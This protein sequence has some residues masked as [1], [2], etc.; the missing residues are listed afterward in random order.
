MMTKRTGA[1]VALALI[2]MM[3]PAI[4]QVGVSA[5]VT[6]YTQRESMQC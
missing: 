5:K 3:S 6:A 1:I 4:A 2:G